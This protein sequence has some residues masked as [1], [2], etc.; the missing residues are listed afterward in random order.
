VDVANTGLV[1]GSEVVQAYVG[2][3][4]TAVTAAPGRPKKE[5][6]AFARVPDI[7]PGATRTVT[8]TV[9]ASDLAYWDT[10]TPAWKVERMVHQLYVGPSADA[11]DPNTKTATFTVE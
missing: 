2:Y 9:K 10:T 1:I 6:K 7:A 11:A 5:L 8:L 4:D 3:D